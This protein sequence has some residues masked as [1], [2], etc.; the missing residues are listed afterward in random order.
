MSSVRIL[1]FE[2]LSFISL[3][4]R[5]NPLSRLTPS[6]ALKHPWIVQTRLKR[7]S[8]RIPLRSQSCQSTQKKR[9]EKKDLSLRVFR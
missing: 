8:R 7:P 6:N 5:W 3:R 2:D 4:I 9:K 1:F